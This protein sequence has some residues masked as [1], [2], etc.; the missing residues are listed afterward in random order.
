MY[1]AQACAMM[2]SCRKMEMKMA[3]LVLKNIKFEMID[4]E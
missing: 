1:K 4:H 3:V 2:C